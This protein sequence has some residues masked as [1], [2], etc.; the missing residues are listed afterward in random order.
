MFCEARGFQFTFL[1]AYAPAHKSMEPTLLLLEQ[2]IALSRTANIIIAGDSN[3]KHAAWGDQ[4]SDTRGSRL[5]ESDGTHTTTHLEAAALLLQT[6]VAVDDHAT[7]NCD[8]D[9]VR[10]I[11]AAPYSTLQQDAPFS[12]SELDSVVR[13]MKDR[14]APGP[15]G[16]IRR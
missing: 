2:A 3:A 16:L 6:Q 5:V 11:V 8:H 4:E 1:S 12:P 13:Q 10:S 15:D 9:A 7:D 14:S